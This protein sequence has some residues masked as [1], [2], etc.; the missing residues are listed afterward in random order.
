MDDESIPAFSTYS[1]LASDVLAD[2][3]AFGRA[4]VEFNYA[5]CN[6]KFSV[7]S[8]CS[9]ATDSSSA[10]HCFEMSHP[11]VNIGDG[12]KF[13]Y[14]QGFDSDH[15]A[16]TRT[17]SMETAHFRGMGLK[18]DL[19]T[20]ELFKVNSFSVGGSAHNRAF[21]CSAGVD[22]EVDRQCSGFYVA[23]S[24]DV[25]PCLLGG[26]LAYDAPSGSFTDRQLGVSYSQDDFT[27]VGTVHRGTDFRGYRMSLYQR[28]CER[29]QC[30]AQ[31]TCSSGSSNTG[32]TLGTQYDVDDKTSFKVKFNNQSD[33][34]VSCKRE[35]ETGVTLSLGALF[36]MQNT[37]RP[38][39]QRFGVGLT[40]DAEGTPDILLNLLKGRL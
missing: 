19:T 29:I 7:C 28:V 39:V 30:A 31:M 38:T 3:V 13:A 27:A 37:H 12:K 34:A 5:G 26:Q 16:M 6:K 25:G 33:L 23:S 35:L 17:L 9:I 32:F 2:G 24:F 15:N 8:G 36:G 10:S 22:V 20:R 1:Q 18:A 4:N 14:S 21:H 11:A 40:F